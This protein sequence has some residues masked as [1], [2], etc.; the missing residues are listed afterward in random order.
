MVMVTMATKEQDIDATSLKLFFIDV[1]STR[2][3]VAPIRGYPRN[4]SNTGSGARLTSFIASLYI[5]K[6]IQSFVPNKSS[7]I[8]CDTKKAFYSEQN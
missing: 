1:E 2:E 7:V 3:R 4:R 5:I 6:Y 8:F